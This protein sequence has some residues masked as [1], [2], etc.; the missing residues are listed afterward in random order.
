MDTKIVYVLEISKVKKSVF[1]NAKWLAKNNINRSEAG[2]LNY[3]IPK[4]YPNSILGGWMIFKL[5]DICEDLQASK[6]TVCKWLKKLEKTNL[7]IH[8]DFRSPLWKLDSTM[9]CCNNK[10][11]LE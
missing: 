10:L 1:L 3:I 4:Q 6:A 5:D 11:A 2:F 7:L 9:I 8:E